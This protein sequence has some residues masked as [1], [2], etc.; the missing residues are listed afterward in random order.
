MNSQR[1]EQHAQGL[2]RAA[3]GLLCVYD[4]FQFSVF[5]GLLSVW[6]LCGSLILVSFFPLAPVDL[7]GPTAT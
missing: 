4:G 3:P 6:T 5:V 2:H 1:L 7:P